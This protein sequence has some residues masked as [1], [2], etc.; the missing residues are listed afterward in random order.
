M[1]RKLL[2]ILFCILLA[3][4]VGFA[5][6]D[7]K[8]IETTIKL[9]KK[10]DY[11]KAFEKINKLLET[12]SNS[13]H[14]DI[15]ITMYH[16]LYIEKLNK[17]SKSES[18]EAFKEFMNKCR[19][20]TLRS[21]SGLATNFIRKHYVDF[22]PDTLA[23]TV[24]KQYC[25]QGIDE[26]NK[27]M[28]KEAIDL[29]KKADGASPRYYKANKL[30]G[31]CYMLLKE[32]ETALGCYKRCINF[33]PNLTEPRKAIVE[34]YLALGNYVTAQ[35]EAINGLMIYPEQ[36][37]F[38]LLYYIK[39]KN[40][41]LLSQNWFPRTVSINSFTYENEEV[42]TQPWNEYRNAKNDVDDLCSPTGIINDINVTRTRYLEVYSWSKMLQYHKIPSPIFEFASKM[43]KAGYLD[44]FVLFSMFHHDV[45][46]QYA[47]FI[48]NPKNKIKLRTYI[49]K[50][51]TT[52]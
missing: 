16:Q 36:S 38:D 52:N 21:R 8:I 44:C 5:Q 51:L 4:T 6:E 3:T 14:W 11:D 46:P 2:A 48:S 39:H 9:F 1:M 47:D 50:M 43:S 37:L 45:Y 18:D 32:S 19:L 25:N 17:S 40:H 24:A 35:E 26:M 23:L 41:R 29:F 7:E 33:A 30:M 22:D 13:K 27:K 15:Y 12:S 20:A 42:I 28:Y 49:D 31:D 34:A 10:G